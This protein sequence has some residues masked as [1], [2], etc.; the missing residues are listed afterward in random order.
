MADIP[1]P[2]AS[3]ASFP[4]AQTGVK[5]RPSPS[6]GVS[7]GPRARIWS[8]GLGIALGFLAAMLSRTIRDPWVEEDTW[9]GAVY[10]QA[11][12]NNLRAGVLASGG[13]PATL[14]FGP[15]PIP[16]DAFYVHHPTLLPLLVTGAFAVFGEA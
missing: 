10:S 14:Y 1:Q 3:S 5:P 6:S 2:G 13:V 16:K 12:H 15:L 7:F 11:A 4:A 8:L 9:Y